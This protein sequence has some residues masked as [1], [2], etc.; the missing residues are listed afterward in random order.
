[1]SLYILGG[2]VETHAGR[3]LRGMTPRELEPAGQ[4]REAINERTSFFRVNRTQQER[5]P[6]DARAIG[7]QDMGQ[8]GG[9]RPELINILRRDRRKGYGGGWL[10]EGVGEQSD[11]EEGWTPLMPESTDTTTLWREENMTA[12]EWWEQKL[13]GQ[14]QRGGWFRARF[15]S[16]SSGG[17]RAGGGGT[18]QTTPQFQQPST[19]TSGDT[20]GGMMGGSGF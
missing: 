6:R 19:S 8:P 7:P 20:G 5:R 4:M 1:M 2:A 3:E 16:S 17:V 12:T 13:R 9:A 14:G 10:W 18:T 15:G 11:V